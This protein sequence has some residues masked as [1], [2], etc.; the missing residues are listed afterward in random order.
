MIQF[1][2]ETQ[3]V[4][5]TGLMLDHRLRRWANITPALGQRVVL[6]VLIGSVL[7]MFTCSWM[8]QYLVHQLRYSGQLSGQDA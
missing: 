1:W 3:G 8:P 2:K 5:P 7:S 6:T 4:E